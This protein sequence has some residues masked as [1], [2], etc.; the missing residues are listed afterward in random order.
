MIAYENIANFS[1]KRRNFLALSTLALFGGLTGALFVFFPGFP[2]RNPRFIKKSRPKPYITSLSSG[3][4][5]NPKSDIAHYIFP[6]GMIRNVYYI[7]EMRLKSIPIE[8]FKSLYFNQGLPHL[9]LS[10]SSSSFEDAVGRLIR[11]DRIEQ[12]LEL[13]RAALI[14]DV[15][16]QRRSGKKPSLR[17]YDLFA[18]L[19]VRYGQLQNL[20]YLI[21]LI[22]EAKQRQ[23]FSSRIDKWKDQ[24]SRWYKGWSD[25]TN[26]KQWAGLLM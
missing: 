23:L 12:A 14:H 3:F 16:L 21:D 9:N 17:L 19:S 4:Y 8:D 26:S 6:N 5:L 18:G 15:E 13:L 2:R 7:N 22:S 20:E 25:S 24:N 11:E 10:S 1:T